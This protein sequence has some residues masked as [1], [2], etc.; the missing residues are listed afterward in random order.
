MQVLKYV[1]TLI[2]IGKKLWSLCTFDFLNATNFSLF[3]ITDIQQTFFK[4]LFFVPN[5]T[6]EKTEAKVSVLASIYFITQLWFLLKGNAFTFIF[7]IMFSTPE[8]R[9]FYT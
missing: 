4:Y 5:H 7:N 1:I 8:H 6:R 9:T 2:I 3:K